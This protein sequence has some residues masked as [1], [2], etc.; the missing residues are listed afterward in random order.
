MSAMNTI[1][2]QIAGFFKKTAPSPKGRPGGMMIC[3]GRHI[4]IGP[5]NGNLL[6]ICLNE[7]RSINV[8]LWE[9]KT[10]KNMEI[11]LISG[12]PI[13]FDL[14]YTYFRFLFLL[15][16]NNRKEGLKE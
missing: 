6:C 8:P 11:Y 4:A 2:R 13:G 14:K 16:T 12:A 10:Y 7:L 15:K 9:G 5:F 1:S 3:T